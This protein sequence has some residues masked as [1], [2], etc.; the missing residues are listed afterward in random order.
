LEEEFRRILE[1][2]SKTA[3]LAIGLTV[4]QID[5]PAQGEAKIRLHATSSLIV[6]P[7]KTLSP[8]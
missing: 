8:A 2:R 1:G 5:F 3:V 7:L 4:W 6:I